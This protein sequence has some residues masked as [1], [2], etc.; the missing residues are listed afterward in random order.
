MEKRKRCESG[1]ST[2]GDRFYPQMPIPPF[3]DRSEELAFLRLRDGLERLYEPKELPDFINISDIAFGI[4][5]VHRLRQA[6]VA[7]L[8]SPVVLSQ[9]LVF[10]FGENVDKAQTVARAY[11]GDN[12]KLA[13][14][15]S[16]LL[17]EAGLTRSQ[18]QGHAS[19][20]QLEQQRILRQLISSI[21]A[22]T[23][24]TMKDVEHRKSAR[25]S[26][27]SPNDGLGRDER[28][29]VRRDIS[30]QRAISVVRR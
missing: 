9:L 8:Q 18:I 28:K 26:N 29:E 30:N 5:E 16:D 3:I 12:Q 4:I 24:R 14:E 27:Q 11:Y 21:E 6:S 22:S 25:P 13:Q 10:V 15:A 17:G 23:R 1:I 20:A 19:I 7:L 2:V